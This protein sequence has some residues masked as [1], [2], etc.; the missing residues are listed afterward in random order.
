MTL[1]ST[2]ASPVTR[3][4]TAIWLGFGVELPLDLPLQTTLGYTMLQSMMAYAGSPAAG[5]LG[6]A[7][8]GRKSQLSAEVQIPGSAISVGSHIELTVLSNKNTLVTRNELS[9]YTPWKM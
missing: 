2:G 8:T 3:E 6:D 4:T 5:I 9:V 1:L 7:L